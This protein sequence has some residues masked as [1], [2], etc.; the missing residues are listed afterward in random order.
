MEVVIDSREHHRIKTAKQYYTEHDCKVQIK[1]LPIGQ[2]KECK[3]KDSL[4][5]KKD[6]CPVKNPRNKMEEEND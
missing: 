3:R 5:F 4:L 2:C 1:E 6:G